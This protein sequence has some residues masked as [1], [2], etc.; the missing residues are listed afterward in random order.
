MIFDLI[1]S[2]TICL[3]I[4]STTTIVFTSMI[5][6]FASSSRTASDLIIDSKIDLID[7]ELKLKLIVNSSNL[8]DLNSVRNL[9][10]ATS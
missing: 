6:F 7:V 9:K 3:T 4:F 2:I 5:V 8:N 10:L 1:V